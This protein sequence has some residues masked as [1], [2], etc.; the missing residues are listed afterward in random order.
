MNLDKLLNITLNEMGG[1]AMTAD[2]INKEHIQPTLNKYVEMVLTHIPHRKF[3]I[4]GSAGK[5]AS[6]GDIDL[7]FDTDLSIDEVGDKLEELGVMHKV[8]KG[9]QQI[10]TGFD[11]YDEDGEFVTDENGR[12]KIVQ[13]DLMFGNPD[14]LEFAYW[15]PSV[16]ESE[17]PAHHRSALLAAIIRYAEELAFDDGSIQT[18]VINWGSGIWTKKRVKY[19]ATKG[20]YKGQEREKQIKSKSPVVTTPQGVADFLT[21]AT[22]KD[23]K[24]SELKQPFEGLWKKA[25]SVFDAKTMVDI[26]KYTGSAIDHRNGKSEVKNYIVP[27]VIRDLT[28]K[29]VNIST[30][31]LKRLFEELGIMTPKELKVIHPGYKVKT[32]KS[33]SNN[34]ILHIVYK[35]Y[36]MHSCGL[37]I[38]DSVHIYINDKL[39][40]S[41]D[42]MYKPQ[43]PKFI[44][45]NNNKDYFNV[46]NLNL[47]TKDKHTGVSNN[48]GKFIRVNRQFDYND[49]TMFF[50][51]NYTIDFI[52]GYE[53]KSAKWRNM[54]DLCTKN[55]YPIASS[56]T[57]QYACWT[58]VR[59]GW[60]GKEVGLYHYKVGELIQP[61][62]AI[63]YRMNGELKISI[64]VGND[65]SKSVQIV[66]D[67]KDVKKGN[68]CSEEFNRKLIKTIFRG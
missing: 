36:A 56:S 68:I 7:G 55:M 37:N 28:E 59:N 57:A 12:N 44:V 53:S 24:V 27:K 45:Y 48:D 49:F 17:F 21:R 51:G 29:K 13:I 46:V 5:K 11:Q 4:L 20:K 62:P 61:I 60:G 66:L 47:K 52:K 50:L 16:E 18:H 67:D 26:A 19:V 32:T 30:N 6:S 38:Y 33:Q 10:W 63:F 64:I 39:L 65:W 34:Y 35:N 54:Y 58:P 23:W 15:S 14:W 43:Q 25:A 1:A 41:W 31:M 40:G 9:F 2:R 42:H 3:Q 8:G 22:G